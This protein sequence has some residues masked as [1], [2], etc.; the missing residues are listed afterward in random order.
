MQE[1]ALVQTTAVHPRQCFEPQVGLVEADID[2]LP[3]AASSQTVGVAQPHAEQSWTVQY[4]EQEVQ[5]QAHCTL[6][7]PEMRM[8]KQEILSETDIN[9]DKPLD[10]HGTFAW[11]EDDISWS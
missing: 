10:K 4:L 1:T 6:S 7:H 2:W 3:S 8:P 11:V 9:A 5:P